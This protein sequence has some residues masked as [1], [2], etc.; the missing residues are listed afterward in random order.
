MY[1]EVLSYKLLG[2]MGLLVPLGWV[3]GQ[4]SRSLPEGDRDEPNRIRYI[5]I[6][7]NK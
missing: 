5:T 2:I 4:G 1:D 7:F 6:Q 3:R